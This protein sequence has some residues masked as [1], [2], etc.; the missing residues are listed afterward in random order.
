VLQLSKASTYEVHFWFRGASS[1]YLGQVRMSW[2]SAEGQGHR[3]K[4]GFTSV[5]CLGREKRQYFKHNRHAV[6]HHRLATVKTG[7]TSIAKYTHSWVVRLRF[8][9]NLVR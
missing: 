3:S 1:E 6:Q 4:R 9:G 2:S 8:E 7:F 5:D